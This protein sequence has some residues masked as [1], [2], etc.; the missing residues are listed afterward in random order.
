M[1]KHQ[2]ASP[3]T[4][5]L[6][7][8]TAIVD[9]DSD[10]SLS[11]S[12]LDPDLFSSADNINNNND[13]TLREP[14]ASAF[15]HARLRSKSHSLVFKR[16]PQLSLSFNPSS[17]ALAPDD[18]LQDGVQRLSLQPTDALPPRHNQRRPG[19]G[20]DGQGSHGHG[21]SRISGTN[22][23]DGRIKGLIRRASMSLKGFVH[24][25]KRHSVAQLSSSVDVG[26]SLDH[27]T[28]SRPS[29]STSHPTW[30]RRL[31]QAASFRHTRTSHGSADAQA[32]RFDR[33]ER[34]EHPDAFLNMPLPGYGSEPPIIPEHTGAGA[35]AAVAAAAAAAAA[36]SGAAG[37]WNEHCKSDR[38]SGIG[39]AITV[40]ANEA[41]AAA[42]A[43]PSHL[44][45][46]ANISRVD[47]ISDLPPELSIQ[48]L[49]YLDAACLA[50]ASL[51][52]R[53]WD[54]IVR[55]RHVWKDAFLRAKTGT[56]ATGRP[57]EPGSSQGVPALTAEVD[58]RKVYQVKQQL[59]RSW[60]EG[61]ARPVY[62]NGHLDSIYCLQFDESKIVT[63][64]RDRTI[65]IWDMH[66]FECR[67]VIGPPDIV[68]SPSLLLDAEGQP[69]HHAVLPDGTHTAP[70]MPDVATFPMH[71]QASILCL[72]YD[73]RILVTGSSDSTCIVYSVPDGYRPLRRL[74]AHTAAVLDLAFD[75]RHIVTCSKD[76]TICVWD[77]ETGTLLRRLCGHAGPVNAVQLRG[78]TIVSCSG[79]FRVKL[80]NV[81]TGK[82]I[83]EF[84]GHTKGLACSQFTQDGRYVASAGND[85]VIRV[86]DANTGDCV[87]EIQA[88]D[89]LVRSLHVDSVSGRL[90]SGSY[91]TDIKVFDMESGRQMLDFPRWHASWV[92]SAKSDYRRIVSTGQD[93]KILIMDFGADID[94]IEMLESPRVG[95]LA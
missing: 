12:A 64:S 18:S 16:R 55:N 90:V 31:R 83:R 33:F 73:D 10:L 79:D 78:N 47:F 15:N 21:Q 35:K 93:P 58:W 20:Q 94:G 53:R 74:R 19:H 9:D 39:I 81:D 65:R 36:A 66:T 6:H 63:G 40:S 54:G 29:T 2:H 57:I 59:D 17:S 56:Y 7:H 61:K 91:D 88:H 60:R 4:H 71:H 52:S 49:A 70:S 13:N 69:V 62:L 5:R 44:K 1:S 43:T 30:H 27:L 22:E 23:H 50:S 28:P 92:L 3:V 34:F 45:Q 95:G 26:S 37:G 75:D 48:I 89:G 68:N 51:V 46:D 32:P 76:V 80:W 67:L 86:W 85:K 14:L 87:R 84:V 72:Q 25:S 77:R 38:E 41:D 11:H 82:N 8:E 24:H 42:A